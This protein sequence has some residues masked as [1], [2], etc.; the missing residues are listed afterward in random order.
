MIYDTNAVSNVLICQHCEKNIEI[1]KSLPCGEAICSHCESS[2][3][4]NNNKFECPLCVK[5]HEMPLDGLPVCKPLL[6]MLSLKPIKLSRGKVFDTLEN[7]L[8]VIKKNEITLNLAS[9]TAMI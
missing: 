1:P 2:I 5:I 8:D 7:N 3:R 9:M 6:A 4:V